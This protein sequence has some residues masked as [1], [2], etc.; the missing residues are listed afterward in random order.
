[1]TLPR[2]S[3]SRWPYHL[4]GQG[5][6]KQAI[7]DAYRA[8]TWFLYRQF[9]ADG[10]LLYVGETDNPLRREAG[11]RSCSPWWPDVARTVVVECENYWSAR[12]QELAAI[13]TERPLYNVVDNPDR[14]VAQE[15]RRLRAEQVA[16]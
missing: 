2:F 12:S 6:S 13:R 1:V 9:D 5:L 4:E 16:S 10:T 11:H 14:T 15:R 3:E 8:Q 7:A